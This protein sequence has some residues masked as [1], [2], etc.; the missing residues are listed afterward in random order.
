MRSIDKDGSSRELDGTA[1]KGD[2]KTEATTVIFDNSNNG[3]PISNSTNTEECQATVIGVSNND[4][5]EINIDGET[6]NSKI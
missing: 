2:V 6:T 1:V 4:S 3:S 5:V